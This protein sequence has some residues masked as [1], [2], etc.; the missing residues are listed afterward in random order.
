MKYRR[1]AKTA[2]NE[3]AH[4]AAQR[5]ADLIPECGHYVLP[6]GGGIPCPGKSVLLETLMIKEVAVS[7]DGIVIVQI[8]VSS[9]FDHEML[10]KNKKRKVLSNSCSL[11]GLWYGIAPGRVP[12]PYFEHLILE[13]SL[14]L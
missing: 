14:C 13:R 3:Q 7:E 5:D 11:F 1:M 6:L 4:E 8:S 2:V 12:I 10:T 9:G